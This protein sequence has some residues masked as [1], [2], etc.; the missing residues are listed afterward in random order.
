MIIGPGGNCAQCYRYP[1]ICRETSA[2]QRKREKRERAA[3]VHC[4]QQR[5]QHLRVYHDGDT[6]WVCPT[7]V[8]EA[9]GAGEP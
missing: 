8:Y 2:Q 6:I 4:G 7:S 3:C 5:P 9:E 1:C